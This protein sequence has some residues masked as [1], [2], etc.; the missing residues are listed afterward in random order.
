MN[1][2]NAFT[3]V[4]VITTAVI[5]GF[6]GMMAIPSMIKTVNRSYAKDAVHNLMTIYAAQQNYHQNNGDVYKTCAGTDLS[7]CINNASGLGLAIVSSGGITYSCD[8]TLTPPVCTAT[9][10]AGSQAGTFT[11]QATLDSPITTMNEPVY[12]S[13]TT[14]NPCCT[15]ADVALAGKKCP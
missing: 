11:L 10:A 7:T 9:A 4:E 6:L 14:Y 5:V 12:C 15:T 8:A 2:K 1:N 3:L 13:S